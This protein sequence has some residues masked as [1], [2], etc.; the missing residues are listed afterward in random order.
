MNQQTIMLALFVA[1]DIV[2]VGGLIAI[3]VIEEADA[4]CEGF[5]K[6]GDP[7]LLMFLLTV[8]PFGSHPKYF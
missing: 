4:K 6:N 8:A 5:K 3:P 1:L 7:R 2:L